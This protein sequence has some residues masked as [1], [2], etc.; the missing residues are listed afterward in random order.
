MVQVRGQARSPPPTGRI[1]PRRG[2]RPQPTA[3]R[4]RS[5]AKE[6]VRGGRSSP[7]VKKGGTPVPMGE[8]KDSDRATRVNAKSATAMAIDAQHA[9]Q[10]L[11]LAAASECPGA[12]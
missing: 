1:A 12:W 4:A 11:H 8:A 3:P 5:Q 10:T 9:A 2:D 6:E 7:S